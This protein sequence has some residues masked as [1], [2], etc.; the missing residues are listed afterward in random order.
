MKFGRSV[1][2]VNTHQLMESISYMMSCFQD[3]GH[4][5]ISCKKVL[6]SGDRHMRLPGAHCIHRLP[7]RNSVYSSQSIAHSHLLFNCPTSPELFCIS[8]E[9]KEVEL[10]E[11]TTFRSHM[12]G[13]Q[14]PGAFIV[15]VKARAVPDLLLGNLTRAG[16]C[17]ICKANPAGAG[18]GFHHI[19][20]I[21]KF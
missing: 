17:R 7:A 15:N 5:I 6:M 18:A 10:K 11:G 21:N 4:Y 13:F 19:L 14:W 12:E 2:Q 9:L 8:L 16:F 3:G 20:V 1:H